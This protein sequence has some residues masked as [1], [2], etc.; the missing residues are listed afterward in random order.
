MPGSA[1]LPGLLFWVFTCWELIVSFLSSIA[2]SPQTLA[3]PES[4]VVL[5]VAV[6]LPLDAVQLDVPLDSW[7]STCQVSHV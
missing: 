6:P 1:L 5:W 2:L 7:G 4:L 3:C